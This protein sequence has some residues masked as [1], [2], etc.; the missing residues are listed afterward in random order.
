MHVPVLLRSYFND[1]YRSVIHT[2]LEPIRKLARTLKQRPDN[3]V[4]DCTYGI[5]NGVAEGINS[6]IIPIKPRQSSTAPVDIATARTSRMRSSST[7][8]DRIPNHGNTEWSNQ[9]SN[10]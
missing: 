8:V 1:W 3:I 4:T 5:T 10:I 9:G 6:K 2:G 7:A